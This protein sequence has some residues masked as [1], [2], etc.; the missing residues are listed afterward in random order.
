MLHCLHCTEKN[1]YSLPWS[2]ESKF[3]IAYVAFCQDPR[4]FRFDKLYYSFLMLL[5]LCMYLHM[6][7]AIHI[8]PIHTKCCAADMLRNKIT[9]YLY[10]CTIQL[11]VDYLG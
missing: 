5:I 11:P 7:C 1:S 9:G 3:C 2:I 8:K 6:H 10:Y 4:Q